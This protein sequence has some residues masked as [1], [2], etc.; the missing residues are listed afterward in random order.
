MVEKRSCQCQFIYQGDRFNRF[1]SIKDLALTIFPPKAMKK[2]FLEVAKASFFQ[3]VETKVVRNMVKAKDFHELLYDKVDKI[4][5]LNKVSPDDRFMYGM[6]E[7][8][9][10]CQLC[11][12]V[13]RMI[14]PD[15]PSNGCW[16]EVNFDSKK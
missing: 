4:P 12:R 7:H 8:W 1:K 11:G 16:E 15:G 6:I 13:W 10:E 3:R 14:E 2:G 9:Y 5:F